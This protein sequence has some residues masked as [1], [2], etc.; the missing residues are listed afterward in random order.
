MD[1][2]AVYRIKLNGEIPDSWLD[3]LGG[4]QVVAGASGTVTLQGPLPDQAA[5]IGVLNTLYQLRLPVLEVTCLCQ[6][7]EDR[8]KTN[9]T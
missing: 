2:P 3:R 6:Q 1:K 4:V 8:Q 7:Q 5:L 9:H